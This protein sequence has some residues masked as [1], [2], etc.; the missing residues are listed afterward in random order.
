MPKYTTEVAHRLGKEEALARLKAVTEQARNYSDLKGTRELL[1]QAKENLRSHFAVVGTTERFNETLVLLKRR[2]GWNKEIVSYP[3]NATAGR[4]ASA[5]LPPET[6][7]A[8]RLRNELDF[9]LWEFASQLM[10]EMIETDS[11]AF[12]GELESYSAVRST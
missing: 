12:S 5:S 4:P 3:R 7:R 11:E 1:D 8:I 2:L 6:I 9:E 10:D